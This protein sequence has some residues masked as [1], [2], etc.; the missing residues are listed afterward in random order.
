M[1]GKFFDYPYFTFISGHIFCG[2]VDRP[3]LPH[4]FLIQ[5][6]TIILYK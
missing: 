4:K 5:N 2:K 3:M 6:K 1:G